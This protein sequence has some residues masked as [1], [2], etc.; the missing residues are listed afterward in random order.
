MLLSSAQKDLEKYQS[1]GYTLLD[2]A[3]TGAIHI[4]LFEKPV[5]R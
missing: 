3:E 1:Q 4:L 2:E 5:S